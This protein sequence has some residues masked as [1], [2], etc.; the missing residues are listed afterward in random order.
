MQ[1]LH[2]YNHRLCT[3]SQIVVCSDF[4]MDTAL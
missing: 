1:L 4:L 2:K 3:A